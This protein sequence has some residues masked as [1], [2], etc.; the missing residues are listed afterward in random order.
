MS[1]EIKTGFKFRQSLFDYIKGEGINR[2]FLH[3]MIDYSPGHAK[4]KQDNPESTDSFRVGDATHAAVL[5]PER[6]AKE[7]VTLPLDCKP[8]SGTG[9]KTRKEAFEFGA[10]EKG[11]TIIQPADHQNIREMQ[12]VI[13]ADQKAMDLLSNGESE[14]SGYYVDPDYPHILQKI[15]LDWINKEERIIV[16][17][18]TSTDVRFGPFRASVYKYGYDIQAYM[19][20]Y[21]ATQITGEAHAEFRF[22]CIESKALKKCYHG[23]KIYRAD[24]EMLNT[25]YKKYQQ[26]MKL[27]SECL[28]KDEWPG[29]NSECEDMGT[30]EYGK[31]KR[32][33]V[34]WD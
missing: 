19:G 21:G 15:R 7:Y 17:L 27:Y 22:I 31:E 13:Q 2:S 24:D 28:E 12:A 3:E 14:I 18:K 30:P 20:L 25:G 26:A 34:I 33:M 10:T 16:D 32:D 8:G 11:Q 5:E 29:Y 9:M 1:E 23:L 4:W 6:F